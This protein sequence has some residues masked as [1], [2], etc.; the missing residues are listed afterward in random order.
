MDDLLRIVAFLK[1]GMENRLTCY[2]LYRKVG[3][4]KDTFC[5]IYMP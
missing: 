5:I 3:D 1:S 2:E 4:V